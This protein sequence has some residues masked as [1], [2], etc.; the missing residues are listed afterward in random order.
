MGELIYNPFQR[1]WH[2]I[3]E[4]SYQIHIIVLFMYVGM[5]SLR[6]GVNDE[7]MREFIDEL[8]S[9]SHQPQGSA[10]ETSASAA[11]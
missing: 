7:E 10:N 1:R 9:Q 2:D 6:Y 5:H 11:G 3:D 4:L 8:L